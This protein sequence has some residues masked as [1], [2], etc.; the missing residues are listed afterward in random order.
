MWM[1]NSVKHTEGKAH[2]LQL[3]IL[4]LKYISF[5]FVY[6]QV[7]TINQAWN[8]QSVRLL[9]VRGIQRCR[10]H[11]FMPVCWLEWCMQCLTSQEK[12]SKSNCSS[13][14]VP[15]SHSSSSMMAADTWDCR[16]SVRLRLHRVRLHYYN[17]HK[18]TLIKVRNGLV[19]FWAW[20]LEAISHETNHKNPY[21]NLLLLKKKQTK[22]KTYK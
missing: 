4:I 10:T 21:Y 12:V 2:S 6:H 16:E 1:Q 17:F 14:H 8:W 22:K 20:F 5:I 18:Y 15:I 3:S 7:M 13:H 9:L 19:V 11:S